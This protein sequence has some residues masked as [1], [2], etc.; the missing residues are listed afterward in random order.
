MNIGWVWIK[1]A[2][3]KPNCM[4]SFSVVAFA[5]VVFKVIMGG[6]TITLGAQTLTFSLIDA[7][8]IAAL[9]T[10]TLTAYVARKYTDK[11]FDTDGD[12][13]PDSDVPVTTTTTTT[14][15]T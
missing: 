1:D 3:G 9:L 11:K 2:E 12:G 6:L 5:I 14:K 15:T 10:P 13:I 8:T 7:S 4:L